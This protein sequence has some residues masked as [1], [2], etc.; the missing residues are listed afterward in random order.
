MVIV[1]SR[2]GDTSRLLHRISQQGQIVASVGVF[3]GAACKLNSKVSLRTILPVTVQLRH[4]LSTGR[5]VL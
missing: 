2:K 3:G 4:V 5:T 1:L